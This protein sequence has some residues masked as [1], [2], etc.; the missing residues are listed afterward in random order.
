VLH[1]EI[2]PPKDWDEPPVAIHLCKEHCGLLGTVM[3]EIDSR[4]EALVP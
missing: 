3:R 2:T 1:L 4:L